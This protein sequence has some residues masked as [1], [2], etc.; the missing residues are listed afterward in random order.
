MTTIRPLDRRG[1]SV[2]VHTLVDTL[3]GAGQLDRGEGVEAQLAKAG[4]GIDVAGTVDALGDGVV[5]W[6]P[7]D[8]VG[9]VVPTSR[10]I[11]RRH[12]RFGGRHPGRTLL[13]DRLT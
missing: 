5:P 10:R 13:V 4:V 3:R 2:D 1:E 7:G 6:K 9:I 8:R 11:A 12:Q